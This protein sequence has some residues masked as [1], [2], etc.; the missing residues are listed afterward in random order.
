MNRVFIAHRILHYLNNNTSERYSE[1]RSITINF[2]YR[3]FQIIESNPGINLSFL[4]SVG[5]CINYKDQMVVYLRF[6]KKFI[7][8]YINPEYTLYKICEGIFKSPFD[9]DWGYAYRVST[10]E[11][12]DNFI[13]YLNG[14]SVPPL[15]EGKNHRSIPSWIKNLVHERDAGKCLNCGSKTDLHYD[16]ILP[17]SKGGTSHNPDNIQLLCQKC[18]L[19]KSDTI[20]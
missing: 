14:L 12:I 10:I 4:K 13:N 5:L 8:A 17:F 9:S 15:V 16:H 6:N 2:L 3:L 20:I 19:R 7:T 18:N 1:W 11:E